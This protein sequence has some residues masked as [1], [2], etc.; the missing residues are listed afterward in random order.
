[1]KKFFVI[2]ILYCAVLLSGCTGNAV[3][4][5]NADNTLGSRFI[6]DSPND[7]F[8][9][10]VDSKTGIIYIVWQ[11]GTGSGS[12]G[13]ICPLYNADGTIMRDMTMT[14]IVSK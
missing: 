11:R 6:S 1:M 9:T 4:R 5:E 10:V 8:S 12:I 14:E 13:G 7:Y 2:F 3:V